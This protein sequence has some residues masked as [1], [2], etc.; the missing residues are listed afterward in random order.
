[1]RRFVVLTLLL[2][3]A[4]SA[5][6]ADTARA[7]LDAFTD[8]LDTLR[9][10]FVQQVYDGGGT[11]SDT[12]SGT[13]ALKAPRQFRW[14]YLKPFPQLIVADGDNVWV[15]DQDL[16]QVT[17]RAQSQEE[18]QSPLTVLTDLAQL[19]RDYQSTELGV[20]DGAQ[21]LRLT[22]KADEPPFTRCD[23]GFEGE[24]LVRMELTDNLGQRNVL[25]FG[26]WERNPALAAT[27]FSFTPPAG[28][29]VVGEPVKNAEVIP[30]K[31]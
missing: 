14:E 17:V 25:R 15:F 12:S 22:S 13:L 6:S 24:Q 5:W 20:V 29:D 23:L 21:V 1:M 3:A 28:V 30:L 19:D 10:T 4:P 9:G 26:R 31:D 18:A 27:L 2:F 8:K 16:D 7:R 11:L